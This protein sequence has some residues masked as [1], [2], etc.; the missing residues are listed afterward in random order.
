M[1]TTESYVEDHDAGRCRHARGPARSRGRSGRRGAGS[2]AGAA[3]LETTWFPQ[4]SHS[5][6]RRLQ[7]SPRTSILAAMNRRISSP[8][9]RCGQ[10]TRPQEAPHRFDALDAD[11]A[12]AWQARV[13][14]A[15]AAA[16][17]FLDSP[18]VPPE[19]VELE[20]VDRGDYVREKVLLRTSA[21]TPDAGLPAD[22]Q[23]GHAARAGRPRLSRPR[24]RRQGH[25]RLW[26]DGSERYTPD[27]YHKDFAVALCRRGF[28]GG[29][30]GDLLLRRA[31]DRLLAT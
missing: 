24:L 19:P 26:E 27:G 4:F 13:R 29:R 31:A 3:P 22:A 2:R 20:R 28:A 16:L 23:G 5:R 17:G 7:S 10:P 8:R 6:P 1:R 14:P 30:A 21:R 11:G 25:R 9:R 15:F 12:R 18:P